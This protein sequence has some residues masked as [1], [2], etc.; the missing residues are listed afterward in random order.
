[1]FEVNYYRLENG[2][3]PVEQ[4]IDSLNPKMQAKAMYSL[5][6]LEEFG[7][8]L[9]EPFSKPIGDGIFELRIK[10]SSDITRIF[11]YFVGDNRIILTNGFVKKTP[12]TPKEE[13]ELARKY[14][15]DYERRN[16]HE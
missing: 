8:Q 11:Y 2:T 9:R 7:N 5:A 13:I 10:F 12:K 6:L 3:A 1:M 4:F 15:K 16:P 14:K